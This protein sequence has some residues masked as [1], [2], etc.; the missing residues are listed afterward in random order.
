L[1]EV[2]QDWPSATVLLADDNPVDQ[3]LTPRALTGGVFR[4]E[5]QIVSDGRRAARFPRRE[6]RFTDPY[7][8]LRPEVLLPHWN[9][10]KREPDVVSSYKLGCSSFIQKPLGEFEFVTAIEQLGDYCFKLV[11]LP[12]TTV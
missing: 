11:L 1:A 5:L 4:C 7:S 6:G 2:A 8:A 9:R 3:E 12:G 10:P